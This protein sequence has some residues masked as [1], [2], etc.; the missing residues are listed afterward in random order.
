M[1]GMNPMAN[2]QLASYMAFSGGNNAGS[3]AKRFGD[4]EP[5]VAKMPRID[6]G[7][8]WTCVCGNVNYAGRDI[9]NL[10]KCGKP[11]PL[12][13]WNCPNCGNENRAGRAFCNMRQCGI[14]KP[15][16]SAG[17]LAAAGMMMP[18]MM[19]QQGMVHGG[20]MHGG[21]MQ[22][23]MV[24][25]PPPAPQQSAP[26]PPAGSWTCIQCN[27]VNFPTRDTCNG[28]SCGRPRA[29]VDGGP[30]A[31]SLGAV[32]QYMPPAPSMAPM[33]QRP[34]VP[35]GN[36]PEGSWVCG[37]CNNVNYPTRDT[38]NGKSCQKPR[39]E[40]DAGPPGFAMPAPIHQ[41]QI[42]PQQM[43]Q[44]QMYPQQMYGIYAAP[45]PPLAPA[46][47]SQPPEGSWQCV[48]CNN[49]NYP[50]RDTCNGR[51]CN[52]PR[53]ECDG[54]PPPPKGAAATQAAPPEGSWTCPACQNTNFPTRTSCNRRAC[55]QPRPEGI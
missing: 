34:A 53:A 47:K 36:H 8:S 23:G 27:N 4:E 3:G 18:G 16:L 20:P 37:Q 5:G 13:A 44:P 40:V 45:P 15:G 41:P 26:S 12:E 25:M 32:P 49:V 43:H 11:R 42:Y 29:E 52:K 28:R 1:Y 30:S 10:R 2:P 51:S 9:C 19:P 17:Q 38:C 39:C 6:G 55:G 46:V 21:M 54:G 33:H 35:P 48:A 31:G 24:V 7:D 14:A 22:G 50:T